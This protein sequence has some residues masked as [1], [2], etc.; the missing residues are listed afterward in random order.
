MPKRLYTDA[1]FEGLGAVLAQVQDGTE[2]VIAYASRSLS[3]TERNDQNYSSFKLELL[4]LRWAVTEKF[5]NYL[6]GS[7][8][9]IFTDNNPLVH[10]QTAR[11]G[12][13]EQRWVSQLANFN[14]TIK[15]RPG[16]QNRNADALSRLPQSEMTLVQAD[17]VLV[18]GDD[19]WAERQAKDPDLSLLRQL[20]EQQRP[21]PEVIVPKQ[22]A[23]DVWKVYHCGMGHPSS[24]RTLRALKERCYWP[25]MT[26]DIKEWTETCIQCVCA[27]AG[28][29]C[30]NAIHPMDQHSPRISRE[31]II[32]AEESASIDQ[33]WSINE[34]NGAFTYKTPT[35]RASA[36]VTMP[37]VPRDET[38]VVGW[39]QAC[40]KMEVY[41]TYGDIGMT[42]WEI[43]GLRNRQVNAISNSDGV[44]YPWYGDN[45]EIDTVTGPTSKPSPLKV[46]MDNNLQ[47]DVSWAVPIGNSN[48]PMLTHIKRDQSFITWLV[49][50]NSVTKER[51]VLRTVRWRV[52][53]DIALRPDMPLGSR[54]SPIRLSH[55]EQPDILNCQE[56]IPSNVLGSPN[57]NEAQVLM[58]RPRSGAPSVIIPARSNDWQ[59][60][61]YV[62]CT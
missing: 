39:I 9:T 2:R 16:R 51:I 55:Q 37:P 50:M 8:F 24:E 32:V 34:R 5:K 20:K 35:F 46:S 21:R 13:V 44:R 15:Y 40:T 48:T 62:G 42:S 53:V 12:A 19:E 56:P 27:K 29:E 57:A 36:E 11:F 22:E 38:W 25:R 23:M 54:A 17:Y 60:W 7:E 30:N 10:L 52:Q 6:Y 4:A 49:A 1:S 45:T 28:P 3:P 26:Q 61:R 59:Q 43:P 58:W 31:D 14:Y 41:N 47:A 33:Y 18:E